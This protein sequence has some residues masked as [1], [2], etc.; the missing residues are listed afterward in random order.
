MAS[1]WRP[2]LR[3]SPAADFLCASICNFTRTSG[4]RTLGESDSLGNRSADSALR[5]M[6]G[7]GSLMFTK[8]MTTSI[9]LVSGG[10]DSCVT[11]GVA[12]VEADE[13]AFLHISYGQRTEARER[14]AFE[15]IAD[16]YGVTK[17]LDI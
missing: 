3:R 8:V 10:M 12:A 1:I 7:E 11:A 16:H 9:V 5:L 15:D 14:R 6:A 13:L 4:E 2:W 17:R